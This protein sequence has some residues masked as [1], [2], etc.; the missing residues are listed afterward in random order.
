MTFAL[1]A[2]KTSEKM[3][4]V[5]GIGL[6]VLAPYFL[7]RIIFQFAQLHFPTW[8]Q[9]VIVGG[10]LCAPVTVGV[11]N[12]RESWSAVLY[13]TLQAGHQVAIPLLGCDACLRNAALRSIV[14]HSR[15]SRIGHL[16]T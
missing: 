4:F 14:K 9:L 11:V 8:A 5:A 3:L 2:N 15:R 7:A 12:K 6:F 1:L 13:S 16:R 10:F